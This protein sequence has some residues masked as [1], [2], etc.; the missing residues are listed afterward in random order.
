MPAGLIADG[1]ITTTG[2]NCA[3]GGINVV[4]VLNAGGGPT[5]PTGGLQPNAPLARYVEGADMFRQLPIVAKLFDNCGGG[6]IALSPPRG[7][8]ALP[9][10]TPVDGIEAGGTPGIFGLYGSPDWV[11]A[12]PGAGEIGPIG[13]EDNGTGRPP[14]DGIGALDAGGKLNPPDDGKPPWGLDCM[15]GGKDGDKDGG[16]IGCMSPLACILDTRA[17]STR[18]G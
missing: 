17:V 5:K 16:S 10:G 8:N 12:G 4:A 14:D 13:P 7:A 6:I 11:I 15:D 2:A 3:G 9:G 1:G 18:I